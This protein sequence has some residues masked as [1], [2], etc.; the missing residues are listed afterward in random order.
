MGAVREQGETWSAE[1]GSWAA[2]QEEQPRGLI[3]ETPDALGVR[4]GTRVPDVGC[5]PGL[6]L[7]RAARRGAVAHGVDASRAL[8][9]TEPVQRAVALRGEATVRG[10]RRPCRADRPGG[11][12][13][14]Q[15]NV[16]EYVIARTPPAG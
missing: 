9:P 5:G 12:H 13:G 4:P 14:P 15:D 1:A 2:F 3:E 6:A 7:E 16:F 11:R 8:G 10:L